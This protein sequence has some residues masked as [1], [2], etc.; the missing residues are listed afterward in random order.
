MD[1]TDYD[2]DNYVGDHDGAV[3][4]NSFSGEEGTAAESMA[5]FCLKAWKSVT[6][7]YEHNL[8]N[9]ISYQQTGE[10]LGASRDFLDGSS[11]SLHQLIVREKEATTLCKCAVRMML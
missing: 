10:R 3:D 9:R 5:D 1:D 6:E 8:R 11:L 7:A 2:P 4:E